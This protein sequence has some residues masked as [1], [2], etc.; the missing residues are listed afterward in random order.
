[1]ILM[2]ELDPDGKATPEQEK[3][4]EV[5]LEKLNK[6]RALYGKPMKVTSGLRAMEDH[7]RIYK[8]KAKKKQAPFQDGVFDESKVPMKSRHL[9]GYAADVYDPK[10]E[11]QEWCKNNED[12]LKD[13]GLWMESFSATPNWCHFQIV[14]YG[15]YK[16]GKSIWFNP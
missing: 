16:E 15:S 14:P 2:K 7:L 8:D 10:K 4:L 1:M 13:I 6:V 9:F 3:N 11:L 12:K 5:L